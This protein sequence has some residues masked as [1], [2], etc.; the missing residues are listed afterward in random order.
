MGLVWI[1]CGVIALVRLNAGW[2]IVPGIF[3]I[4]VGLYFLRGAAATIVR[5]GGG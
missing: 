5:R 4:G 3:F 2:K 1:G